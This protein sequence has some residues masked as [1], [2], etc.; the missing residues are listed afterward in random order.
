MR[1]RKSLREDRSVLLERAISLSGHLNALSHVI[2]NNSHWNLNDEHH[3]SV[4]SSPHFPCPTLGD[5]V[6]LLRER[7]ECERRLAELNENLKSVE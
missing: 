7:A 1:E 5:V 2:I 4:D 3:I 6:T